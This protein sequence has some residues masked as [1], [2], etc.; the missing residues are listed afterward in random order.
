MLSANRMNLNRRKEED[1]LKR[2]QGANKKR[3]SR[4]RK[5]K[6]VKRYVE[7]YKKRNVK[8]CFKISL[9]AIPEES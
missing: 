4:K 9:I 3:L 2:N 8:G 6:S 7:I 5:R 1:R